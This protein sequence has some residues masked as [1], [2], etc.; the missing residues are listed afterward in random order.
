MSLTQDKKK[1]RNLKPTIIIG[2][3]GMTPETIA[4]IKKQLKKRGLIKIKMLKSFL[5]KYN[6][7]EV[8]LIIAEKTNSK[9]ISKIGRVFVLKYKKDL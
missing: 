9:L 7:K 2:K 5:K 8:P 3:K 1:A 6:K 4:E